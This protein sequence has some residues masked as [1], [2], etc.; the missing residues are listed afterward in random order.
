MY[1]R[2]GE[3]LNIVLLDSARDDGGARCTAEMFKYFSR[4]ETSATR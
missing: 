1:V 3:L 4:N 2:T